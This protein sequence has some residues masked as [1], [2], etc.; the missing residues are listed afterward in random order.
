MTTNEPIMIDGVDVSGCRFVYPNC[1]CGA[2]YLKS[3]ATLTECS[4]H[5]NCYYK[6]LQRKTA[7]CE[8]LKKQ[9]VC[10]GCGTCNSK[11]DYKNMQRHLNNDIES[12][13]KKYKEIDCYKQ[14]LEEIESYFIKYDNDKLDSYETLDYIRDIISK[15]KG[16]ENAV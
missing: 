12:I 4:S 1:S 5:N 7:E 16:E 10:Y 6:Q 15:E 11:E 2:Y 13:H 9:V 3:F 14:A 8:E